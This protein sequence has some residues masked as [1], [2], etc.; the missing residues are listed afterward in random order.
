MKVRYSARSHEGNYEVLDP[1]GGVVKQIPL[2]EARSDTKLAAAITRNG[3][4][5]IGEG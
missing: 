5:A 4:P 3:W 2:D 1:S